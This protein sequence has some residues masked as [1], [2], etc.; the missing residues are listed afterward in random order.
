MTEQPTTG[1][2]ID[3]EGNKDKPPTLLGVLE[4]G[5]GGETFHQYLL[6]DAFAVLAP[7]QKYLQLRVDSLSN[8][9][10]N[11]DFRHGKNIPIYAWSSHEQTTIDEL[12]SNTDVSA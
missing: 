6:E 3:F 12:L 10:E 2:F 8:I 9:L 1:I 4:R 11:I 7:S 5:I